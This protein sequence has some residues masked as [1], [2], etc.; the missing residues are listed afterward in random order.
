[1]PSHLC[2]T[3]RFPTGTFHGRRDH[4]EPEWP[5]SPLRVFQALVRSAADTRVLDGTH[6]QDALEWLSTLPPPEIAAPPVRYGTP[7]RVAV[8]NNDSDTLARAW[9]AG[10]EATK[11]A[12][13]LKTLKTFRP[14]HVPVEGAVHYLWEVDDTARPDATRHLSVLSD[15]ASRIV[16][17][18]WGVDLAIGEMRLLEA[19]DAACLA[20]ERWRPFPAGSGGTPLRVPAAGILPKLNER[21]EAFRQR[22]SAEGYSPPLPLSGFAVR[23]YRRSWDPLPPRVAA[24]ALLQ[25]DASGYRSFPVTGRGL[26]VAGL[27]RGATRLAA[28]RTGWKEGEI[29]TVVLGHGDGGRADD[30]AR[31]SAD[32]FLYVPLPTLEYRGADRPPVVG[33]IRRVVV[34][35]QS[36]TGTSRI[37]WATRALSGRDLVEEG[38]GE[39]LALLSAIP[40]SDRIVRSYLGPAA[41]W[42]TVSPV[43]LPGFDDPGGYRRRLDDETDADTR[44]RLLEKLDARVDRLLRKS[45][46]Q[47]G[48]PLQLVQAVDLDWRSTGFLPGVGLASRYGVPDHLRQYPRVHVRLR[49]RGPDGEPLP[50]PGPL[51]IGSGR[52]YGLGLFAPV[53]PYG[54]ERSSDPQAQT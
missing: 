51:C 29:A 54:R 42:T 47:A 44:R 53:D 16:A 1:M 10:R 27:L 39:I 17:L 7:R 34:C 41:E 21:Y 13:Q 36:G 38:T 20:G 3:I 9:A 4:G 26:T 24:F 28:E 8:P 37:E 6:V 15:M 45:L 31:G 52:F 19:H 2:L 12:S 18:G 14:V 43:V 49:W 46:L 25:S 22:L 11:D 50:L 30:A 5:P 33:S 32:R 40:R 35:A 23:D 48:W